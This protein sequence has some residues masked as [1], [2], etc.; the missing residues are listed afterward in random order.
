MDRPRSAGTELLSMM[1]LVAAVVAIV[2]LVFFGVG[3]L[4]GRLF[5]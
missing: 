1:A 3:Y 5:L 2:I 4:F